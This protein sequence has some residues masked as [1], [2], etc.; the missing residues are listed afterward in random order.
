M[1][2]ICISL[3]LTLIIGMMMI[4]GCGNSGTQPAEAGQKEEEAAAPEET[5]QS[6]GD[7]QEEA[8]P[9]D[10]AAAAGTEAAP[11]EE[12]GELVA[13]FEPNKDYDKYALVDYT[14]EDI[15]AHFVATVSAMEDESEYEVHCSVDGEEQVVTLDKDLSITSDMTGNMSYDAPLIVKKAIDAGNWIEITED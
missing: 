4:T 2:R 6:D 11:T 8:V 7:V 1:K 14:V 5:A 9:A 3:L 10:N 12:T 15:A 13:E